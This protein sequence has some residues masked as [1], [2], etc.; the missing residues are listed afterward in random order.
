MDPCPCLKGK[1]WDNVV[2]RPSLN[3]PKQAS[4]LG[5]LI[6]LLG[7]DL[8][9]PKS[10]DMHWFSLHRWLRIKEMKLFWKQ[11]AFMHSSRI[12]GR[13]DG[14]QK[15]NSCHVALAAVHAPKDRKWNTIFYLNVFCLVFWVDP[16]ATE[17]IVTNRGKG[18]IFSEMCDFH[19]FSVIFISFQGQKNP[20]NGG[21][22]KAFLDAFKIYCIFPR[23]NHYHYHQPVTLLIDTNHYHYHQ[24]LQYPAKEKQSPSPFLL[25]T[26]Q[27]CRTAS[28]LK[29][30]VLC[31]LVS[32]LCSFCAPQHHGMQ[33]YVK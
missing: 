9:L 21:G 29:P 12:V 20:V 1:C 24:H 15:K 5:R 33:Y 17:P 22:C 7:T 32:F 10:V 4:N 6:L 23:V 19:F 31:S 13:A 16:A 27:C 11:N 25:V 2:N 14:L 8:T 18:E 28:F 3:F 30:G 26:V